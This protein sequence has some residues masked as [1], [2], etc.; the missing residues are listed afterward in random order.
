MYRICFPVLSFLAGTELSSIARIHPNSLAN[1][2]YNLMMERIKAASTRG[3]Q[4]CHHPMPLSWIL[5][6]LN[7][8]EH[9]GPSQACNGTILP[10]LLHDEN[11][12]S[13]QIVSAYFNSSFLSKNEEE[14][15]FNLIA[16]VHPSLCPQVSKWAPTRWIF[17]KFGI[18]NFYENRPRTSRFG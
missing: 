8:L 11:W 6:N 10:F 3:W 13:V 18:R 12:G 5:R 1:M 7:L 17:V 2:D 14:C 15:L 16:C 4:P 9:S